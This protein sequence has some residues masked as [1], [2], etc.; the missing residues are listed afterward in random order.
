MILVDSLL[1]NLPCAF[2]H[3]EAISDEAF[4]IGHPRG[5]TASPG[6]HVVFT[7]AAEGSPVPE[8]T[9][10]KDGRTNVYGN[11]T[12]VQGKYST[13]S[14]LTIYSVEDRH[15]G[16]YACQVPSPTGN[17]ISKEAL[18]SITGRVWLHKGFDFRLEN[19][20]LGSSH[21]YMKIS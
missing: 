15:G 19:E 13:T 16:E 20:I 9:W 6:D 3:I 2:L 18:L 10:L 8:I 4:F 12:N 5:I 7:C 21:G 1:Q 11:A 14:V 17:I